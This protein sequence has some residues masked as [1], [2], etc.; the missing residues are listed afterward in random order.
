MHWKIHVLWNTLTLGWLLN[1][2]SLCL[3]WQCMVAGMYHV[4]GDSKISTYLFRTLAASCSMGTK[5][6]TFFDQTKR[7]KHHAWEQLIHY[8]SSY[9]LSRVNYHLQYIRSA[10]SNKG[11]EGNIY[12]TFP[13]IKTLFS[14]SNSH[15]PLCN[16]SLCLCMMIGIWSPARHLYK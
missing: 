5:C 12:I 11:Y 4:Q 10:N 16:K 7:L 6:Y 2:K 1:W 3:E 9:L 13:S 15:I 8:I 14:Q